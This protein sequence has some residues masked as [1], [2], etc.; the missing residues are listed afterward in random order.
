MLCNL[1]SLFVCVLHSL[2]FVFFKERPKQT[3]PPNPLEGELY[4][5]SSASQL[6]ISYLIIAAEIG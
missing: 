4:F 2:G 6:T 5:H 1:E 3:K